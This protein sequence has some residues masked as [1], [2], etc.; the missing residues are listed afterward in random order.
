MNLPFTAEDFFAVFGRYNSAIWPLQVVF[1]L[2]A[3]LAAVVVWLRPRKTSGPVFIALGALWLWE[4]VV[5]HG[6]FFRPI[7]PAA[8]AFAVLFLVQAVLLIAIALGRRTLIEPRRDIFGG[9]GAALIIYALVL[10]PIVGYSVGHRYP[11]NP[12]FGLPCPT[13]LYTMGVL[14]WTRPL[15]VAP[16]IVPVVW[17]AIGFS[18]ALRLGVIEDAALLVAGAGSIALVLWKRHL[19]GR[20]VAAASIPAG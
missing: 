3:V 4:A 17:C 13:T 6:I 18:A 12:T 2:V 9:A 10:Y 5:Y 19:E 11:F 15:R 8:L 20:T 16:L 7:N 1:V 14:L